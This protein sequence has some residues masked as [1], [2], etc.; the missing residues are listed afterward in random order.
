MKKTKLDILHDFVARCAKRSGKPA[1]LT[2]PDTCA[3]HCPAHD[4]G[5][6]ALEVYASDA[7]LALTCA[8]GCDIADIVAAAG[9]TFEDIDY[10]D[11]D[12]GEFKAV[13]VAEEFRCEPTSADYWQAGTDPINWRIVQHRDD[14][15][16][17]NGICYAPIA[18]AALIAKLAVFTREREWLPPRGPAQRGNPSRRFL[19]DTAMHVTAGTVIPLDQRPPAWLHGSAH[20]DATYDL[21][22]Q[23]GILS[24]PAY[25][26]AA[27]TLNPIDDAEHPDPYVDL[28]QALTPHTPDLFSTITLPYEFDPEADCPSWHR[29]LERVL[30]GSAERDIIQEWFGY[31]LRPT[32]T[33]QRVLML[34]GEGQNGKSILTTMLESL[35]GEQNCSSL[36]L[37]ALHRSH[38]LAGLVGK[39]VNL[40]AEWC[41]ND[42]AAIGIL[43]AIS[44]GDRVTIDPKYK[45]PYEAKLPARFVIATNEAPRVHDKSDAIWRRLITIP[46]NVRI[47]DEER[48]PTAELLHELRAELDGILIWALEGLGRLQKRGGFLESA[49]TAAMKEAH[50]M[51]S[52]PAAQWCADALRIKQGKFLPTRRAHHAYQEYCADAGHKPLARPKF[53]QEIRRWHERT[54]GS[55]AEPARRVTYDRNPSG[56]QECGYDHVALTSEAEAQ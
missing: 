10:V 37:E 27:T 20:R 24:I 39:L 44:G 55:D 31:C 40:S 5:T 46:F 18:D 11:G 42:P 43:K 4:A 26:R 28:R 16:V 14:K 25:L 23:N 30:P 38:A 53:A 33:F 48:R 29:F 17:F 1:Q 54:T 9:L 19:G 13:V 49:A 36:A 22:V 8:A 47:P 6:V 12:A 15:Y 56:S 34:Q 7:A 32:Q 50:R 3:T 51:D 21:I 45:D 52:N 41:A 2:A 35:V